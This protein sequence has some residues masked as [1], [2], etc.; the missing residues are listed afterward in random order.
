MENGYFDVF[1]TYSL[2]QWQWALTLLCAVIIGA[3]R[4]GFSAGGVFVVPILASIFGG[5]ASTGLLLPILCFADIIAVR[6][7]NRHAD[8]KYLV[9]LVPFIIIGIIAGL[10]VGHSI[11]AQKF[12]LLMAITIII[13]VIMLIWSDLKGIKN[14]PNH[15][16]ISAV[17]GLA[18]GFMTM[19]GNVAGPVMYIYLLSMRLPKNSFIGTTAWFFFSVNLIKVPLQIF[20]WETI[21]I[22]SLLFDALHLPAV[23]IGFFLGFQL[24]KLI[25]EHVFRYFI[26]VTTLLTAILAVI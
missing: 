5:K 11:S 23:L 1:F 21:T 17:T 8:W 20:V 2:S 24:I 16:S 18:A 12:N 13:C 19:I 4:A 25:P 22:K 9:K 15:W 6:Y 3:S 10:L 14:V 26:I 7:Y